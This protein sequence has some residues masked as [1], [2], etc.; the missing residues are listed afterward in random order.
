LVVAGAIVGLKEKEF[1]K[2]VSKRVTDKSGKYRFLVDKGVYSLSILNSDL[3]LVDEEKYSELV[4]EKEGGE[5]L[6]PRIKVKRL[7]D[8]VKDEDIIEP[9]DE[10]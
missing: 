8:D 3:K 6:A 4:V 9:L 1:G 2:L 7:E 5:I 10:L